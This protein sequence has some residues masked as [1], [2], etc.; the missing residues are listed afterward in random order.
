MPPAARWPPRRARWGRRGC[1]CGPPRRC[2][3]CAPHLAFPLPRP[4]SPSGR[5]PAKR[6][7]TTRRGRQGPGGGRGPSSRPWS[8]GRRTWTCGGGGRGGA[9]GC[10]SGGGRRWGWTTGTGDGGRGWW[11]WRE[12][13]WRWRG[14]GVGVA[15]G[16]RGEREAPRA[17]WGEAVVDMGRRWCAWWRLGER[18]R[19]ERGP[20]G[21]WWRRGERER[22]EWVVEAR[23]R[24][25]ERERG[26]RV[27]RAGGKRERRGLRDRASSL[28]SGQSGGVGG[29]WGASCGA[30]RYWGGGG[31]GGVPRPPLT[32]HVGVRRRQRLV[33]RVE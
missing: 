16:R 23:R 9:W 25:G 24:C 14:L 30:A 7:Q 19:R 6:G 29:S 22:R 12:W 21:S 28:E 13:E 1:G 5:A 11:T 18:E 2:A 20:G 4:T 17:S 15:Y 3:P 27:R 31:G 33:V 26:G 10:G 8:G 32:R